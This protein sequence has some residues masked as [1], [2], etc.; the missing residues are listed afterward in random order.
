MVTET[1]SCTDRRCFLA[2]QKG[3]VKFFWMEWR[4][5]AQAQDVWKLSDIF[6]L[7]RCVLL[8]VIAAMRKKAVMT[9]ADN[10]VVRATRGMESIVQLGL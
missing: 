1:N 9:F 6:Q 3:T 10:T 8:T 7:L 5:S 2:V 4:G